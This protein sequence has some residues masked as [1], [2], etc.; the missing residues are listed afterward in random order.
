MAI[1]RHFTSALPRPHSSPKI[2]VAEMTTERR[3]HHLQK[4]KKNTKRKG[5]VGNAV[6][7]NDRHL[8]PQKLRLHGERKSD[9]N[10]A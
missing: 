10:S 9:S 3:L 5:S 1:E 2:I 8:Q 6:C 7:Y 4:N